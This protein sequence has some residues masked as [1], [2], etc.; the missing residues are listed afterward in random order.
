MSPDLKKLLG[1][2]ESQ[3]YRLAQLIAETNK[4]HPGDRHH[5]ASHLEGKLEDPNH[6]ACI[7]ELE[8]LCVSV[9]QNFTTDEVQ[10]LIDEIMP[11]DEEMKMLIFM[12]ALQ[13]LLTPP[14]RKM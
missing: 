10:I 8:E 2:D 6:K 9:M 5:F 14:G 13:T 1:I 4:R 11:N 7:P 3:S 12:A